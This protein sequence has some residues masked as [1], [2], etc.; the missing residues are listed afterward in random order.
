MHGIATAPDGSVYVAAESGY[1]TD[2]NWVEAERI[3]VFSADGEFLRRWGGRGSEDAKFQTAT[4]IAVGAAGDVYVVDANNSLIQVFDSTGR[5]I[6]KWGSQGEGPGQFWFPGGIAIDRHGDVYVTDIGNRRVQKFSADGQ[7]RTSWGR[8]GLAPGEF[9][10]PYAIAVGPDDRVYV[11]DVWAGGI[12]IFSPDGQFLERWGSAPRPAHDTGWSSCDPSNVSLVFDWPGG[13][14]VDSA[15]TVYVLNQPCASVQSYTSDGQYIGGWRAAEAGGTLSSV[16]VGIDGDVYVS[17][18]NSPRIC[19]FGRGR[20]RSERILADALG[21]DRLR[22]LDTLIALPFGE[23]KPEASVADAKEL[24]PVWSYIGFGTEPVLTSAVWDVGLPDPP[25]R[26]EFEVAI[27]DAVGRRMGTPPIGVDAPADVLLSTTYENAGI[28]IQVRPAGDHHV[29]LER[30]SPASRASASNVDA[31]DLRKLEGG[32][33]EPAPVWESLIRGL[34][35]RRPEFAA[36]LMS[37]EV[38]ATSLLEEVRRVAAPATPQA[39]HDLVLLAAD[40]WLKMT[41]PDQ[42]GRTRL[43]STR[44]SLDQ[45]WAALGFVTTGEYDWVAPYCGTVLPSLAA[46]VGRNEWADRAFLLLLDQ[47]WVTDCSGNCEYG[48]DLVAAVLE[49]GQAYLDANDPAKPLW[50]SVAL[51]VA[52]AHETAWSLSGAGAVYDSEAKVEIPAV[53]KD[54]EHRR[55]ALELYHDL[56]NRTLDTRLKNAITRRIEKLEREVDTKCS[57]YVVYVEGGC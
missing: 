11:T 38:N 22:F 51:R 18:L 44:G 32:L 34:R 43:W 53:P 28:S 40:Q 48:C 20:I 25:K 8:D 7:F 10:R 15:G 36:S 49:H 56:V 6:R 55:R 45:A 3:D 54:A 50:P 35:V 31:C 47:G 1:L 16:A 21:A 29:R 5:L 37:R 42:D 12:Q 46:G 33:T 57:V 41:S 17:G 52:L 30:V 9:Q 26:K 2:G 24:H 4:E 27:A 23:P 39:D 13:I 14:A 19:R